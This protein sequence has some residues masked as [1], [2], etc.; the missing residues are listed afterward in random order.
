MSQRRGSVAVSAELGAIL[1]KLDPSAGG[2]ALSAPSMEEY[3]AADPFADLPRLIKASE[4]PA[5]RVQILASHWQ[6]AV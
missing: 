3:S 4:T 6:A 5:N 2:N 1:G